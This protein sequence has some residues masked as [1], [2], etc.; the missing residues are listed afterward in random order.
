MLPNNEN[1]NKK[2]ITDR[3]RGWAKADD[4]VWPS[5]LMNEAANE[6][7]R[8]RTNLKLADVGFTL[9]PPTLTAGS[10]GDA[11][12]WVMFQNGKMVFDVIFTDRDEAE[13]YCLGAYSGTAE[14]VGVYRQPQP[15]LADDERDAIEWAINKT[16]Q[17]YDDPEG[18]PI[19]REVMRGLLKRLK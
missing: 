4:Q 3:L 2:N 8:L 11:I 5:E 15:V 6:I 10:H 7:E 13:K 18:G 12:G 16:A 9:G 19:K 14:V 17:G 1:T